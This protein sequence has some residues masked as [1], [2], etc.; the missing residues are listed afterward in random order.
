MRR[1]LL[2]LLLLVVAGGVGRTEPHDP[3]AIDVFVNPSSSITSMSASELA[4]IYDGSRH[5]WANG[6]T[7]V[8][9]NLPAKQALRVEF[10][11]A[12]LRM[13]PD[14]VSRY[15]IDQRIRDGSKPPRQVGEPGLVVKLV[16]RLPG[17]IGYAPA[18]SVTGTE[19]RIVAL[20]RNEKVTAK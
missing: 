7:V 3:P 19:V 1:A 12:V 14:Q 10:D 9:F 2:T 16:A 15:W 20:I 4:E 6:Q 8:A 5:T 11:H 18:G 17:A 13:S